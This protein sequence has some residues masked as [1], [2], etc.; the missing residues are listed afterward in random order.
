[1]KKT[2]FICLLICIN[3]SVGK[4][5]TSDPVTA[6]IVMEDG[7]TKEGL[8]D[9]P[10]TNGSKNIKIK[11][12]GETEKI[13]SNLIKKI[14]F[15]S[16]T[17]IINY[18]NM[19]VYSTTGNKIL[20]KKQFL[21]Y[22][23]E[24]KVNLYIGTGIINFGYNGNSRISNNVTS[25]YCIR[26]GEPAAKLIH[27]NFGQ[28]NKNADFKLYASRYFED[29]KIIYDKIKNKEYTYKDIYIVVNEYNK[30]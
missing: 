16:G 10:L 3:L 13:E 23:V 7:T 6:V 4:A 8:V 15:K 1:M 27:E 30:K 19:K 24:G 29:N 25:Y 21:S 28:V 20:D 22:A 18:F 11:I 26:D 17:S 2:L 14:T 5:V 9:F 12:N